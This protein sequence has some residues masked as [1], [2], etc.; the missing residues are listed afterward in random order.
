MTLYSVYYAPKA[1][2][3]YFTR[4]PSDEDILKAAKKYKWSHER[5][6]LATNKW[7]KVGFTVQDVAVVK[8]KVEQ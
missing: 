3:I 4:K 6:D 7:V 8:E 2:T 1:H 5:F